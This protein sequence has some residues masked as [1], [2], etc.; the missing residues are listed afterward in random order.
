MNPSPPNSVKLAIGCLASSIVVSLAQ[1]L[2]KTDFKPD[3]LAYKIFASFLVLFLVFMIYRRQNWARWIV[4]FFA[5]IWLAA[6]LLR[7][8]DITRLALVGRLVFAAQ[9]I[10]WLAAAFMIFAPR[11]NE[12]FR[13]H[14]HAA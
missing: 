6:I 2:V 4:A 8:Q 9:W 3:V 11:A 5:L 12:W 14:R 10:L 7:P 1:T 13:T